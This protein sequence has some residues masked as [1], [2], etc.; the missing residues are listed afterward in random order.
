MLRDSTKPLVIDYL[1][2]PKTLVDKLLHAE[3]LETCS[4]LDDVDRRRLLLFSISLLGAAQ[5]QRTRSLALYKLLS[6]LLAGVVRGKK[7]AARA[8][9]MER[10]KQPPVFQEID[11]CLA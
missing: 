11:I 7:L 6:C 5:R 9:L 10:G 4:A 1:P 8:L 3:A 2:V